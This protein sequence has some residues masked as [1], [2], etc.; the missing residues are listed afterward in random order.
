M[1]QQFLR[2]YLLFSL[3]LAASPR[4]L[5]QCPDTQPRITGPGV[6]GANASNPV[7]YT[8]PNVTGHT[9]SWVVKQLPGNT[10]ISTSSTNVLSQIWSN[11]GNYVIEL[12]E[13]I[14]GN[15]CTVVAA[16]PLNVTVRPM[17][18]AYF[19]YEFDVAHGCFYNVVDFTGT[20]DGQFPPV[21]PSITYEWKWRQY[22]SG[23]PWT[24]AGTNRNTQI[25]FPTQ[26][27]ITYEVLYTVSKVIGSTT[28]TDEI[29]DYVYVDPDKYKPVP[30][31]ATPTTPNCTYGE[32]FFDASAS[33]ATLM[34]TTETFR[35]VDWDFGD[36]NTA[37]FEKSGSVPPQMTTSHA[38][39]TSPGTSYTVTLRL[40]NTIG[41]VATTSLNITVP[42]SVPVAL[43]S[44]DAGCVGEPTIF[45]DL[46]T[47][48]VEGGAIVKWEWIWG[49]NT[50]TIYDLNAVP[51]T[52]PPAQIVH[53]YAEA[54]SKHVTLQVTN[55][56][57]CVSTIF[58][59]Y[60]NVIP[61]PL[62]N[63]NYGPTCVDIPTTFYDVS[64][65]NGG[66]AIVSRIWDF[67]EGAP[68][69]SPSHT[70][71]TPGLKT[72]T[73]TVTNENG[74]SDI[75]IDNSIYV[76]PLPEFSPDP[77]VGFTWANT[78]L[79]LEIQFT[80]NT[81]P[82]QVGNNLV[83]DFGDGQSG[84]GKNPVH[85]YTSPGSYNV[86]MTCTST[87]G[88]YRTY[89]DM[90]S[91]TPPVPTFHPI[92]Y[93]ACL[94]KEVRFVPDPVMGTIV[95]EEWQYQDEGYS[96][97]PSLTAPYTVKHTFVPPVP[98]PAVDTHSFKSYGTKA[99]RHVITLAGTPNVVVDY[100]DYVTIHDTA[101]ANFTWNNINQLPVGGP[102]LPGCKGQE[103]FFF[104]QSTPPIGSSNAQIIAWKWEF[105]DPASSLNNVAYTKNCSHIFVDPIRTSFNVKLTVTSSDNNCESIIIKVISIKALPPVN[106]IVNSNP[107]ANVGCLSTTALPVLT[108]FDYDPAII[109]DPLQVSNWY[110]DYGDNTSQSGPYLSSVSH[111]YLTPGWKTVLLIITDL[112]GCRNTVSKQVYINPLP[113]PDFSFTTNTCEG[114][115]V[116]FTDLSLPGGGLLNDYIV[117]WEWFW[118]DGSIPDPQ[119]VTNSGTVF[120][121]FP[122]IAGQYT[123]S[124]RLRVT[125]NYGCVNEITKEVT[126]KPTP[127]AFFEVEPLSPQCTTPQSIQFVDKTVP[128]T[129]TGAVTSWAWTF[130]D[131]GTSTLQNPSHVYQ[132]AGSYTVSLTVTTTNG[133]FNTY[134][135]SVTVNQLPVADFHV[136]T[137]SNTCEQ[138]PIQFIDDSQA[139]AAAINSYLWSFGDG[140]TSIQPSPQHTYSTYGIYQVTLSVTNSNGCI[141]SVT[142]PVTVNPKPIAE[143]TFTASS[144][145]GSPVSFIN[146]SFIISGY[147]GIINQWVWDFGDGTLPITINY[148]YSP[149]VTH[150]FA[151][152]VTSHTVRLTVTTTN[153]C[154]AYKEHI[155]NS[156]P[157]PVS[158]FSYSNTLCIGQ[159][160]QF[161]DESSTNGGGGLQTWNWDFG[162]PLS[163]SNTSTLENPFHIFS[164]TGPFVVSLR[165]TSTN[166]CY[167]DTSKTVTINQLPV[168]DFG[169]STVTTNC[170]GSAIQ[171]VD[172]SIANALG[173]SSYSWNFGDG[174]T[175]NQQSP[176]HTF[177]TYGNFNVTLTI[178]NSNGCIHSVTKP[179]TINPK[180]IAQFT[181]SPSSCVGSPVSFTNQST[182]PNGYSA[183]INTWVWDFD[184]GTLPVVI[185]LPANPNV[186]HTFAGS[187]TIHNV[188]L[189]VTTTSGCTSFVIKTVTSVSKPDAYFSWSG[190]ACEQQPVQFTDQSQTNGGGA[191]QVWNWDF[192]DPASGNNNLATIQHPTHNFSHPSPPD[193]S[194]T[195]VVVNGNGCRDT[196]VQSL[197]VNSRPI[198]D[199]ITDTV[200]LGSLTSFT[201]QST[202]TP[203]PIVSR[204]WEFGDGQ[205]SPTNNPTHLYGT[206]G[207]FLAKLTV[208]TSQGCI[209][210]TTKSVL[211]LGKPVA[212]F[213]YSSPNCAQDSVQ[214]SDISSTPHGSIKRWHWDFGDGSQPVTINFP[215]NPNVK[216][217]FAMGGNYLVTLTITTSDSCTAQKQS[218][219]QI[220]FRPLANFIAGTNS[221]AKTAVQFTDQSQ[222]N[223]GPALT[224]WSWNF[225]DPAS[226]INN[227]SNTQHP[228]HE[229][230]AGGTYNVFLQVTNANGC[231]DSIRKPVSVNPVPVAIFTADTACVSSPTQFNDA[232]T[233]PSGTISAWLWNFGDPSSGS[234]NFSTL[235]NPTHTYLTAGTYAV[236]LRAT[237]SHGCFKDTVVQVVAYP[238]PTAM[239]QYEAACINDSTQ[240]TDFSIAPG[241]QVIGWFWDFGDGTGTATIQNPRYLYSTPGTYEVKLVVTNLTGCTDSVTIPVIARQ[242]PVAQFSYVSFFCPAGKVNF[243]DLST[244]TAAAIVER[245]WIFP[246]AFSNLPNPTFTFS[247]TNQKYAVSLIVTDTYGCR[248]TVVDSVFVKPGFQ[249]SFSNDNVCEGY[250]THFTPVNLTAGDSLYSVSWNFGD[251]STGANNN[252]S[253]LYRPTH[254]FSGPG[255][256]IVKFKAFNT[257]NCVD[258]VY[259]E[260]QVYEAP[261]PMFGFVSTPCDS[262]IQFLDSTAN[263]GTGTIASWKWI[264]GDGGDTTILAPGPGN[265]SHLYVNAGL[266]QVTLVITNSNGCIDSITR[267][268]QRFPC[269]QAVFTVKD[270]LCA[271]YEIA[272][273]DSSLPVSRINQWKWIWG[274]G[275]ETTYTTYT[276][277]VYHTYADSG[278][279]QVRLEINA[280]INGTPITENMVQTIRIRPT[281]V[282]YFSNPSVC[283]N[284]ITLFRDTSNTFGE[285]NTWWRWNFSGNPADTA[286]IKNPPHK[287]DTAGVYNVKLLVMNKYGCKDSL[288]KE[289]RV[290]GLP[291]AAFSSTAACA[292]DPIYFTDHSTESD[293]PLGTWRWFFGDPSTEADSSNLKDPDYIYQKTGDYMVNMIVT[294]NYGCADTVDSTI[295]VN[296]TPLSAFTV[297]AGYNGKQGQIKLNNLSSDAKSYFWDFDNQKYSTEENPVAT[298]TEDGVYIIKLIA[299]NEFECTDTTFYEYRL[300]LKGLYVPNAFLPTS[301]NLSVRLFQPIGINLKQGFYHVAVFDLWG[302]QL[303]ESTK[304]DDK[305]RPVEGWDGTYEGK[306][307]PQGNYMWKI[308]ATFVD[309]TPWTGGD[310]GQ[311]EYK[312]MGTVTLIR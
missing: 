306:L 113:L 146:K 237:N 112:D 152:N 147:S 259:K 88:C 66:S 29:T 227:T 282:T 267:T 295:R 91:F 302:H 9:Y 181:F 47:S 291:M 217:T 13:G 160:V 80:D 162:D 97:D 175:S 275:N 105:D 172:L 208:T 126:L 14:S 89:T 231:I 169:T 86:E 245:Q 290:Y 124:V 268:V 189:T 22:N 101:I 256:Y 56:N 79:P 215:V 122:V 70:Y 297:A 182:V 286:N 84:F 132:L 4:I 83:W 42:N 205:S 95:S 229:F 235:Q 142:K 233:T 212:N 248:D 241:S 288:T 214:F 311:G 6:V 234:N 283:L 173:I 130:G 193:F 60:V 85:M 195:L 191:I 25:T 305:G 174:G 277:E 198:A 150:T 77:A 218:Q 143:F 20:G 34:P 54:G 216:H 158:N 17:L 61:S 73:L 148:P 166:G 168:A 190:S 92:P 57:G 307:M 35:Y 296:V 49:D 74:C 145:L 244:A 134:G 165:V 45:H 72:V 40:E 55:A 171:F 111:A 287:Y 255:T 69:S 163:G 18:A 38:Y 228:M 27:G 12:T 243:Q 31:L 301:T 304:L 137:A 156:I 125:T 308:T 149:D 78:T 221:C 63:F 99:V 298:Y 211:V 258:S 48:A 222:I 106:F 220:G 238:K 19:Y 68:S 121:T 139:N 24:P 272:F 194:V 108:Y 274:D 43:F 207:T 37:H 33:I 138:G 118:G 240:F 133:C 223:G 115:P 225:D 284:R 170:E 299:T 196:L 64:L 136:A 36:G 53:L 102:P 65:Q 44:N 269:I 157:A 254:T 41:C 203:G 293:A 186:V 114:Q 273:G 278:L 252:T 276:P 32:F 128:T 239:F 185:N 104:D 247:P 263:P 270:T 204:L 76:H 184:D 15:T 154:T 82:A 51:P 52:P 129:A 16:T 28:W 135:T 7:V 117:Q 30:S 8:T 179:V 246:G 312:T 226:G 119:V 260:V 109:P 310:I 90:I 153:G 98:M 177:A 26:S 183:L 236:T 202:A 155:V 94:D 167:K 62:A 279:Y 300:L 67:G 209:R 59:L 1:F 242:V 39:P 292:G 266:Y 58:G 271:R 93:D 265:K 103:V 303:W 164:G 250:T 23:N 188:K 232:S 281:P 294:D 81:L 197:S 100:I 187:A 151:G 253:I 224:I 180:P 144:C 21:D 262:T 219:V 5:A 2:Y 116:M 131:S 110:W 285:P 257:D 123:W 46:S 161:N 206:P 192:G 87:D 159:T 251:P 50:T 10:I 280:L 11:P 199:F 107:N 127:V 120:H 261:D 264:W 230:T 140:G 75:K 201:D 249:F 289:T 96:P 200:C 178:M 213:T 3:L 71:A 309:D 141:H 176:Q 210:D